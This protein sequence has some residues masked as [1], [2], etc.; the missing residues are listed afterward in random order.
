MSSRQDHVFV[1]VGEITEVSID[2][3]QFNVLRNC[4]DEENY[5]VT[6]V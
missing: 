1:P 2:A 3:Y 4:S 5:S 6:E